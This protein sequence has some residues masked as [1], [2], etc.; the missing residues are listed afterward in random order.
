MQK[1]QSRAVHKFH[2][3]LQ[4]SALP[5]V[6]G[7][8]IKPDFKIPLCHSQKCVCI[9]LSKLTLPSVT[10]Q[11]RNSSINKVNSNTLII[12]LCESCGFFPLGEKVE[13]QK[14]EKTNVEQQAHAWQSWNSNPALLSA[15]TL[16]T[17]AVGPALV[18]WF[19]K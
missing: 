16:N 6:S 13:I 8:P 3:W 19:T 17:C 1:S 7:K 2:M 5:C 11:K 15:T 14:E 9:F 18:P 10:F 12:F 4:D